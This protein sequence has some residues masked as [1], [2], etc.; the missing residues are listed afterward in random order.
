MTDKQT[1]RS[2]NKAHS[3][4][5]VTQQTGLTI[6]LTISDATDRW[7]RRQARN[8]SAPLAMLIESDALIMRY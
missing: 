2:D 6:R 7:G 1:S 5:D 4:R 8:M 3:L